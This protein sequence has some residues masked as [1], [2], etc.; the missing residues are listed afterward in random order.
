MND[1]TYDGKLLEVLNFFVLLAKLNVSVPDQNVSHSVHLISTETP[2][3]HA[4]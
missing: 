3:Q 2:A 1:E 4:L